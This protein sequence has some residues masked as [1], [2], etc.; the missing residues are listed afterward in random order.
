MKGGTVFHFVTGG[1]DEALQR[2][3]DA[4][5]GLDVRLGGGVAT[6]REYLRAGL[7]DELQLVIA[8]VLLGAGEH[9]LNGIDLRALGY[10]CVEHAPGFAPPRTSLSAGARDAARASSRRRRQSRL[11]LRAAARSTRASSTGREGP[12]LPARESCEPADVDSTPSVRIEVADREEGPA[13]GARRCKSRRH[14]LGA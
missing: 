14:D 8:P 1:I 4:A 2:A 9:L 12:R 7:I 3:K 5:S 6:I 13:P 11:R 10:E